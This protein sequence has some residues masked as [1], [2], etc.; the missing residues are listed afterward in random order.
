MALHDW[1]ADADAIRFSWR[2]PGIL[3]N[4]CLF[5]DHCAGDLD[6]YS[7]GGGRAG[8]RGELCRKQPVRVLLAP[9]KGF[10][11]SGAY[12]AGRSKG[13]DDEVCRPPVVAPQAHRRAA[14]LPKLKPK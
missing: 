3:P 6:L 2:K 7:Q 10:V 14:G 5:L 9:R 12:T 13:S 8:G 1:F 4:Y 11:R